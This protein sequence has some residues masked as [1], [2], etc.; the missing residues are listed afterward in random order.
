[1]QWF[2]FP[3]L[4]LQQSE[5]EYIEQLTGDYQATIVIFLEKKNKQLNCRLQ[6]FGCLWT[7]GAVP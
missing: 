5:N 7:T 2:F 4:E 1:M 3:Q 6:M